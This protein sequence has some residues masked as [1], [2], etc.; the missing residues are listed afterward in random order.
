MAETTWQRTARLRGAGLCTHLLR[1]VQ[2]IHQLQALT[3]PDEAKHLRIF[4]LPLR[5]VLL[6]ESREAVEPVVDSRRAQAIEESPD[7]VAASAVALGL[8][9]GNSHRCE[10]KP[11]HSRARF[12]LDQIVPEA[13][14]A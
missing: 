13:R 1:F 7:G 9:A 4:E 6:A 5:R 10:C 8:R 12:G 14:K 3:E 2:E 11:S